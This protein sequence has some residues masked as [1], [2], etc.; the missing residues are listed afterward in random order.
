MR[1]DAEARL[2]PAGDARLHPP[3]DRAIHLSAEVPSDRRSAARWTKLRRHAGEQ[4][5]FGDQNGHAGADADV[6]MLNDSSSGWEKTAH[7]L[8]TIGALPFQ[9]R[10]RSHRRYVRRGPAP[11]QRS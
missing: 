6:A 5:R 4:V 10:D 9:H 8:L 1:Q 7:S 11:T 2:G 3:S